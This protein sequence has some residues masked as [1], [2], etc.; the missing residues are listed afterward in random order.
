[1]NSADFRLLFCILWQWMIHGLCQFQTLVL[2]FVTMNDFMD[3][4]DS[5][6]CLSACYGNEWFMDPAL[7]L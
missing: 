5:Q 2:H 6:L 1:M 4:T 7:L 3:S